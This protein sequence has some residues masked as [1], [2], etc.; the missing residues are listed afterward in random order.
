MIDTAPTSPTAPLHSPSTAPHRSVVT[1]RALLIAAIVTIAINAWVEYSELVTPTSQMS[2]STPPIPAILSLALVAFVAVLWSRVAAALASSHLPVLSALGKLAQRRV[3]SRDEILAIYLF[4]MVAAAMPSVGI[5]RLILPCIMELQYFGE[6]QNHFAEMARYLP[7]HWAP[8][9]PEAVRTF[10]EGA[11]KAPPTSFLVNVP[12]VGGMLEGIYQFFAQ[13]TVVPWRLWAA[14]FAVW[15]AYLAVYFL[16]SFCLVTLFRKQWAEDDH[17]TFPLAT[18]SIEM[19][20]TGSTFGTGVPFLKDPVMWVGFSL[21]VLYNGLNMLKVFSPGLPAMGMWYPIGKLFTESPWNTM[22]GL[23]VWYKPEIL[24]LGYLVPSEILLSI[25]VFSMIH[26]V[27][28]PAARI[29]GVQTPGLPFSN[30]QATGAMIILGLY[31]LYQARHRIS[32]VAR[33]ALTGDPDIDDSREPLSHR[34][35]FFGAVL[36]IAALVLFPI[37]HGVD[38]WQFCAYFGVGTLFLIAYARNRAETGLPI[39][40]GYPLLKQKSVLTDFL[41]STPF[42][43]A[44]RLQSFSLL[45]VFVFLERG[46]YYAITSLKQEACIVGETMGIGARRTARL[47]IGAAIFGFLVA[48]WMYIASYHTWGGNVMETVG[49]TQGG[50]RAGIALR[51]FQYASDAIDFP[52]P[53]STPRITA[54]VVGAVMTLALILARR[55][56]VAF[57]LHAVGFALASCH[58]NYMWFVAIVLFLTKSAVLRLGGARLYRRLAP[59]FIAFTLGHFVSIGLWSFAGLYG[60]DMIQRY[61]VWFL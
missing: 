40:W 20:R 43:R 38:W 37:L 39:V 4:L 14:P 29:L 48:M 33:K 21:A 56:W 34:T 24:G 15:T 28:R 50:Q 11:D 55:E 26:W 46:T 7:A 60:G 8:L 35:A 53:P 30:E 44:G 3:L 45:S 23:M 57:P 36:G 19:V 16:S 59:G 18:M 31:F 2:E 6:P 42:I 41:G 10:W 54:T 13:S 5:V 32:Q 61:R 1:V 52:Q 47:V 9:D 25:F 17:L 27:T 49:G 58:E 22:S 12:V 51:E